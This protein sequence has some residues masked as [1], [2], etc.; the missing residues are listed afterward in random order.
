MRVHVFSASMSKQRLHPSIKRVPSYG[1]YAIGH[2]DLVEIDP[3]VMQMSA[4][5]RYTGDDHWVVVKGRSVRKYGADQMHDLCEQL[6]AHPSYAGAHFSWGDEW[7]AQCSQ[8][9]G[10]PGNAEAWRRAGTNHHLTMVIHQL[11]NLP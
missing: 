11:S 4:N 2:P 1:D 3:R 10:G 6:V 9:A 8:R 7:I 5:L